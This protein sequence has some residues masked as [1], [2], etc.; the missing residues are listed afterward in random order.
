MRTHA[1]ELVAFLA[2][3]LSAGCCVSHAP[4]PK[5]DAAP[6][7]HSASTEAA[8]DLVAKTV[9]LLDSDGDVTCSG[10]WV[11][12]SEIL[13]ANHC[14]ADL[15]VGDKTSYVVRDDVSAADSDEIEARRSGRL[16]A[17][18]LV[19]DLALVRVKLA[20]AHS[21][22][23]VL[24]GDPVAG[25]AVATMGH[26][27]AVLVWSYSSGVVAAVRRFAPG[28]DVEQWWVQSTAPI[29]PGNSGGGLFNSRGE[30]V[31]ICHASARGAQNLNLYIHITYVRDFLAI[32]L[33]GA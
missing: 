26:P 7:W 32:N 27:L 13:T 9:A 10:V 17:R 2:I 19:H 23:P 22:A 3:A 29:S 30:L 1:R 8:R 11:S 31:G 5:R 24:A 15:A 28:D 25:E 14:V 20:P 21:V 33:K 6:P 4:S 18:D 12:G 16:V